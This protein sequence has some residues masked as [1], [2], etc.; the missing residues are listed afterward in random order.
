MARLLHLPLV[1]LLLL[2][3]A[4]WISVN[5]YDNNLPSI[6]LCSTKDGWIS[7]NSDYPANRDILVRS[8]CV[9]A[10]TTGGFLS[11]S[12]GRPPNEVFGV[13]MCYIASSWDKCK[14]CLDMAPSFAN[15]ECPNGLTGGLMFDKCMVRYSDQAFASRQTDR[16]IQHAEIQNLYVDDVIT[17]N[18]SRWRMMERLI[19]EAKYSEQRYATGSEP[20]KDSSYTYGL[21]QC[22]MDLTPDQC[23]KCLRYLVEHLLDTYPGNTAGSVW[24]FS[25]Y[26]QYDDV[27]IPLRNQPGAPL[28]PS[29]KDGKLHLITALAAAT[30]TSS[31]ML[32]LAM[33]ILL[34]IFFRWWLK[35]ISKDDM[36]VEFS[37]GAGPKRFDYNVLAD[38]TCHFSDDQKLGEGGFGSVYRARYDIVLGIGSALLHRDIKP[39]N[40]MLDESFSA[41][42][43]DFGLARLID[44]GLG[45][46]TTELADTMGYMDPE[47]MTTGRFSTDTM[48][49]TE[50]ADT[51]GYLELHGNGMILDAA[52]PRLNGDFDARQMER[53]LV[54]GLWCTQHDRS[55]RP[56]IRHAV[57]VSLVRDLRKMSE[58]GSVVRRPISDACG[59]R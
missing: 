18:E 23:E 55:Q 9:G 46:H 36:E 24:D 8:I 11:N 35:R 3:V 16:G 14:E 52:D 42:L 41:K 39:S 7:N 37:N 19:P 54:V 1:V 20:Y 56:S 29:S 32:F 6:T 38:A 40:V 28:P 53:V 12:F 33:S 21:L 43:G 34:W 57:R 51:M 49:Y 22:R 50:L 26:A 30:A 44:H 47:C 13:V 31:I 5:A 45:A 59:S 58:S 17:M 15:P 25:C 2:T 27:P 48:G 10:A 4:G